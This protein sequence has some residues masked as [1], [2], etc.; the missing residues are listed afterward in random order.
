MAFGQIAKRWNQLALGEIATGSENYHYA[1]AGLLSLF[2]REFCHVRP[3]CS[4][5]S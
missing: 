1:G 5:L 2:V 3:I 4:S